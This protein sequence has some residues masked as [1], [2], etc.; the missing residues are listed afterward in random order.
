MYFLLFLIGLSLLWHLR[1][2]DFAKAMFVLLGAAT[3]ASA[4]VVLTHLH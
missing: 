1:H 4:V 2:T 3:L